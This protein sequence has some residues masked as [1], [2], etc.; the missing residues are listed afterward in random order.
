MAPPSPKEFIE[1]ALF[2]TNPYALSYSDSE[3]KWLILRHLLSLLQEYPSFRPST[4]RFL[5][6]DG[7]EV[8]LLCASGYVH[9]SN[10]TPSIPLTI[11]LHENYPHKAPLVFVSLDPMTRIHR[12][13][14]FVD[15]SGATTPPYILTWKYP[16]CN[17]S[18]LLH[19]LVQ[20]FSHDHPFS[21]SPPTSSFTHPS[22]V[23]RKEALDRLVGMLYYDMVALQASTVEEIEE[24]SLLQ[25]NLKKRDRFT[26]SMIL[27][28]EQEWKKLKERSNNWAEEAD[29]LVN[30]LKV[31]DRRPLMALAAGD[32]EIEDA[33]EI[34]EKSR[35]KLD[36][37]AADS[38]I[39]DVLYKLD[40]ALE[41]EA[42]SFDSYIK[43]VRSLA[44]EQF[45]L[46]ASEMKL[47]GLDIPH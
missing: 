39:E 35:V 24:L 33:F 27:E 37:S 19:N 42:V 4:G 43:Q 3:Q 46:R 13:H 1:T 18:D 16:P 26:T 17:L 29:R 44:R 32:V 23:S 45:F 2:A 12:H 40:K 28:M 11:W 7:N 25:D 6:N 21:Y 34:D 8:N 36:C 22:L 38:A 20:L 31:N 30:W 41:L 9:V 47:N 14:P 5:H 15:T 10:S